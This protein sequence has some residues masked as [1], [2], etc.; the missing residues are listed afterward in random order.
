[1]DTSIWL[2]LVLCFLVGVSLGLLGGG[3]TILTVPI[4]VYAGKMEA[5]TA[6]ALSLLIV[7]CVSALGA[8]R[9]LK[10]GFLNK[11]LVLLFTLTG[12]PTALLGAKFTSLVTS[13]SLLL[14]FGSL[15][16]LVSLVLLFKASNQKES[17]QAPVCRP[18]A[19]LSLV[20]GSAI[21]FLTGFLGVGGGFLIVPAISIL[22]RCS[23]H[24]AIGTSLAIIAINSLSGFAGHLSAFEFNIIPL[25]SLLAVMVAGSFIGTSAALRVNGQ[26]LQ[27]AFAF[28]I[29]AT[30]IFVVLKN[31]AA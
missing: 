13:T 12:V 11:R 7:G 1:M 28:L 8:I 5:N 3:G 20:T 15:M 9:F 6:I 21:G 23:L 10:Q 2:T 19:G 29:L 22:M 24:T 25:I 30:G 18:G 16:C 4:F 31:L 26:S 17:D 27:K 14:M